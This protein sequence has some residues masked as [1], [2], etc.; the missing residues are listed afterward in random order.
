MDEIEMNRKVNEILERPYTWMVVPEEG[1][2]CSSRIVEFQGC[3]SQGK[4]PQEA[5][6]R[7]R[8]SAESW[9][10]GVL[11]AGQEVP[12][13]NGG[14]LFLVRSPVF[15]AVADAERLKGEQGASDAEDR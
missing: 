14:D 15:R 11:E 12:E 13:P 4:T 3:Y 8:E 6:E 1:G 9:L 10:E 7:L 5:I 2:G